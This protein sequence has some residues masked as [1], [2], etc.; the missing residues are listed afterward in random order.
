MNNDSANGP[1]L[2][3]IDGQQSD[4]LAQMPPVTGAAPSPVSLAQPITP[5]TA[6]TQP[7]D[8][9]MMPMDD[10]QLSAEDVDLI[11]KAWVEKAKAI[12]QATHGNPYVQNKEL[13]KIKAAYIKQRFSRD[14][15]VSE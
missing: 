3:A 15:K 6:V 7:T 11:E 2:P 13:H 4:V 1:T 8:S 12:V 14:V 9:Q 5:V 10:Y